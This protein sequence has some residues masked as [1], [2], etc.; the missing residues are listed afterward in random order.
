MPPMPSLTINGSVPT[1]ISC[2]RKN[3]HSSGGRKPIG[4]FR[5]VADVKTLLPEKLYK[6]IFDEI[7]DGLDI[8]TLISVD[9]NQKNQYLNNAAFGR[10]YDSVIDLSIDLR[11]FAEQSPDVFYDQACMPLIDNTYRVLED[12][13]GTKQV[14]LVPNCTFGLQSVVQHLT[15]LDKAGP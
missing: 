1:P 9:S 8:K 7:P 10:A 15:R 4:S 11:R 13:L 12:F 2:S 5:S 3:H 6:A 14:V